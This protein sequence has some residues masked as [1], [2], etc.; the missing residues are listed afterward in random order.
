MHYKNILRN[1]RNEHAFLS[2]SN[3]H[4]WLTKDREYICNRYISQLARF[5]GTALHEMAAKDILYKQKRP[6]NKETFNM[7]VND[8]IGFRMDPEVR[9]TY[10]DW[11]YGTV[12]AISDTNDILRIH[13]YKSGECPAHM[14]QLMTYAA[15]YCLEHDI[16]PSDIPIE[17]RIYQSNEIVKQK[18]ESKEVANAMDSIVEKSKWLEDISNE[19]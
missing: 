3:A 13:D 18:P 6:R 4:V 17:L 16:H 19:V 5:R 11:C 10:S 8:A 7:Y 14:E 9:L 2:P 1:P 12:D 15:L